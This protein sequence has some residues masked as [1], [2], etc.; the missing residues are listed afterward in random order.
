MRASA[1]ASSCPA[2][3]PPSADASAAD[4]ARATPTAA[5]AVTAMIKVV[6]PTA[7]RHSTV[8]TPALARSSRRPPFAMAAY[9]RPN[10]RLL[11]F[12]GGLVARNDRR[13]CRD[14]LARFEVHQPHA[15]GV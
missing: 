1:A 7:N 13:R 15:G 4:W 11:R 14:V 3:A 2:S 9:L 8:T 5:C 12:V 6:T 10:G